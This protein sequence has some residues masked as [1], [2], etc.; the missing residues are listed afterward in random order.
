MTLQ[1][2]DAG[3]VLRT[4]TSVK[5]RDGATLRTVIRAKFMDGATLRTLATF[6]PPMS[7]AVAP[8]EQYVPDYTTNVLSSAAFVAT[9]TGGT[10]PYTYAWT[11]TG[12]TGTI[13][14]PTSA[15]T[16]VTSGTLSDGIAETVTLQCVVTDSLSQTD[17]DFASVTFYFYNPFGG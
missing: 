14:S 6:T 4:I 2:M 13:N 3:G 12:G 10:G 15:S 1:V 17:T 11:I 9:P 8:V 16:T 5:M 7:L